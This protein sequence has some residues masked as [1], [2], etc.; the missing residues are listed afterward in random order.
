MWDLHVK[1]LLC[2]GVTVCEGLHLIGVLGCKQLYFH[3]KS[4]TPSFQFGV[5]ASLTSKIL[6][7]PNL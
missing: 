6:L 4:E 2:V 7:R 1:V 3:L 5:S